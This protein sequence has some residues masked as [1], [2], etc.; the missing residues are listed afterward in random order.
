[1]SETAGTARHEGTQGRGRRGGDGPTV[2]VVGAGISGLAAAWALAARD[3]APR[4]AVL[5][6]A[7][8]VGGKHALGDVGGVRVDVGAESLLARRPEATSLAEEVGLGDQLEPPR[9]V[10]ASL[11]SAGALRALPPRTLMGVPSGDQGLDGLLGSDEVATVLAEPGRSW[12]PLEDDVDVASFVGARVGRAVVDRLVEPLLGGVYAGRADLLSLRAT[13]PPLW[14]AAV[15]GRS[16]VRTAAAAV[17]PA[18]GPRPDVPAPV[19]AGIRE[20]VGRLPLAVRDALRWLTSTA[21]AVA[22]T[23]ISSTPTAATRGPSLRR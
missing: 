19:F 8:R 22:T 2:V 23:T 13:M 12:A 10:G 14:A 16:L 6:G 17:S 3:D 20:G 4:V 15:E 5:E 21:S 11:W 7:S 1:M 9:P 18:R